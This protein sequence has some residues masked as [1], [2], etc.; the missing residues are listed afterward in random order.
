MHTYGGSAQQTHLGTAPVPGRVP[1]QA[2]MPIS[3]APS[4]APVA[5]DRETA[6]RN[7]NPISDP[8]AS[9]GMACSPHRDT[10]WRANCRSAMSIGC[11][12]AGSRMRSCGYVSQTPWLTVEERDQSRVQSRV[13][14]RPGF[15]SHSCDFNVTYDRHSW[16]GGRE[17]QCTSTGFDNRRSVK[18]TEASPLD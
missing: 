5:K 2:A 7:A 18:T 12:G 8:A 4:T 14:V 13:W 3:R 17:V 9:L 10:A 11:E 16:R 1:G 6:A 15:Q